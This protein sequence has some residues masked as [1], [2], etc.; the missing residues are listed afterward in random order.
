MYVTASWTRHAGIHISLWIMLSFHSIRLCLLLK[1]SCIIIM[2]THAPLSTE[3]AEA[4]AREAKAVFLATSS[5]EWA[6]TFA[7]AR[8]KHNLRSNTVIT[9]VLHL[10]WRTKLRI[11][12]CAFMQ[13]CHFRRVYSSHWWIDLGQI[14]RQMGRHLEKNQIRE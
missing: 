6:W 1:T 12:L 4:Q 3:K 5:S 10:W 7:Y 9:C 11:C 2:R 8:R 13:A 14:L